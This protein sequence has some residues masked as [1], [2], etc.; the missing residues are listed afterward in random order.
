[1]LESPKIRDQEP[2]LEKLETLF[3]EKEDVIE[4]LKKEVG[5]LKLALKNGPGDDGEVK[6]LKNKIAEQNELI[7]ELESKLQDTNMETLIK[8]K[9]ST[10]DNLKKIASESDDAEVKVLKEK[11]A[12]QNDLNKDLMRQL[13]DSVNHE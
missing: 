8:E 5:E 9:E 1:M 11:I 12:E 13:R 6:S 10:I 4:G 3:K 2:Q 7:Q